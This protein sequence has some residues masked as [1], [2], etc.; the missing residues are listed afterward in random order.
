MK[1]EF[2]KELEII[3]KISQKSWT[4]SGL[5]EG[6][7]INQAVRKTWVTKW[8]WPGQRLGDGPEPGIAEDNE[9]TGLVCSCNQDSQLLD[10]HWVALSSLGYIVM[11]PIWFNLTYR[12]LEKYFI[13]LLCIIKVGR[14]TFNIHGT[15][16]TFQPPPSSAPSQQSSISC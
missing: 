8:G 3:G 2:S 15:L 1:R 10:I 11:K 16:N 7:R 5:Q 12:T 13:M 4:N 9:E 14:M 6:A